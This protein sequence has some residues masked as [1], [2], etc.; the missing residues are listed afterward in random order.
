MQSAKSH[1]D[2]E[3]TEIDT[4][5]ISNILL[6]DIYGLFASLLHTH[7]NGKGSKEYGNN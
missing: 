2:L 6:R 5:N 4:Q 3:E 7:G 1:C